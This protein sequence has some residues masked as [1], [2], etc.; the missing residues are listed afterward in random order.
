MSD[1]MRTIFSMGD[2]FIG[3]EAVAQGIVTRYE[4]QR[5]HRPVFPNVHA[6]R[7]ATLCA[8]DR[9]LAAWLWSRRRGIVTGLAAAALHGSRWISNDLD[10]ELI[11]NCPRP[12]QGVIA[13]NERVAEDEWELIAGI[14]VTTPTRTA[15]DLARF[16]PRFEA[17]ARLDA[18]MNARP[19]LIENAI[20]LA[21]RYRGAHGVARAKAVLPMVDGGAA[22]PQ[23]SF[24]R[25]LVIDA[26]FPTPATQI[27]VVDDFGAYVRTL[28]FGWKDYLVAFEYDG[29]QHQSDRKQYLKD[30]RV[31]PILARL[32][33]DVVSVVKEDDPVVVLRRLERS[34]RARG[35]HGTIQIPSYVRSRSRVRHSA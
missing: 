2:I 30:R 12:P 17:L 1:A 34:M 13:R 3:T 23:E 11:H 26:G 6:P 7:G 25:L 21:K 4:L 32:R 24:W 5:W 33:W 31:L 19:Y 22:S 28:D 8:E 9:A 27:T 18:L 35:W 20:M 10:V 15:L 14:P 16:R 29:E